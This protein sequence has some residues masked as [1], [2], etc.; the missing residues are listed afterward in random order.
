[1][2]NSLY[3]L[4][5]CGVLVLYERDIIARNTIRL[6]MSKCCMGYCVFEK[7]VSDDLCVYMSVEKFKGGL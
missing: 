6:S 2:Y 3:M 7:G 1:M 5:M 4:L